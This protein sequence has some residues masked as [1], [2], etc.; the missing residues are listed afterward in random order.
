MFDARQLMKTF[1][2]I[3]RV[4]KS[5][6]NVQRCLLNALA[7]VVYVVTAVKER[8]RGVVNHIHKQTLVPYTA[9]AE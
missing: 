4:E 2:R 5:I 1:P 9:A 7:V 8:A 6:T 3:D